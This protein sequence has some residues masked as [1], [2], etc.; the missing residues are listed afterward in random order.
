MAAAAVTLNIYWTGEEWQAILSVAEPQIM[1]IPE[2]EA[3]ARALA[4][5]MRGGWGGV[6][7]WLTEVGGS[8]AQGIIDQAE[9]LLRT[10]N[11]L[12]LNDAFVYDVVAGADDAS[13][14][15]E[16]EA[17]GEALTLLV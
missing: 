15:G 8:E 10:S 6:E 3:G 4:T 11:T 9:V 12:M 2:G 1:T 16:L 14:L 5:A 7:S 13:L 17:V